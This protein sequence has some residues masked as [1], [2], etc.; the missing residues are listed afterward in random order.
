[1]PYFSP[2]QVGR[3]AQKAKERFHDRNMDVSSIVK[4][5]DEI[6]EDL[7]S[8]DEAWLQYV[9][10]L[11]IAGLKREALLYK[12]EFNLLES[13]DEESE[14]SAGSLRNY[15]SSGDEED[16]DDSIIYEI[17]PIVEEATTTDPV[18]VKYSIKELYSLVPRELT[19]LRERLRLQKTVA[20]FDPAIPNREFI[21][22]CIKRHGRFDR[23]ACPRT[24]VT[25]EGEDLDSFYGKN[26]PL[27]KPG[28]PPFGGKPVRYFQRT[29][30]SVVSLH[31]IDV[32]F[33]RR[34][35]GL[36]APQNSPKREKGKVPYKRTFINGVPMHPKYAYF[37]RKRGRFYISKHHPHDDDHEV[38]LHNNNA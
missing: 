17:P 4:L 1:M 21:R 14:Y 25:F 22:R 10:V 3:L 30:R 28:N 5:L 31:R 2:E 9:D 34:K 27:A 29:I 33:S 11:N 36:K 23:H 38:Y 13:D 19:S 6:S 16:D 32:P 24:S 35:R 26:H 20:R 7:P 18:V 15:V 37:K 8:N 12:K